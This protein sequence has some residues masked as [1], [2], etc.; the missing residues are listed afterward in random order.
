M[1]LTSLKPLP[2]SAP[3][4]LVTEGAA[5]FVF[6][7]LSRPSGQTAIP[8]YRLENGPESA[9][10]VAAALE[11]LERVGV[12]TLQG[13]DRRSRRIKLTNR[14]RLLDDL[15]RALLVWAASV[16]IETERVGTVHSWRLMADLAF[17]WRSGVLILLAGRT[18]TTVDIAAAA[19]RD[20]GEMAAILDRLSDRGFITK[21]GTDGPTWA[22]LNDAKRAM[23]P[24]AAAV[25]VERELNPHAFGLIKP[26]HV[27]VVS[28]L[29]T[30]LIGSGRSVAALGGTF[31]ALCRLP[32]GR[33]VGS[34]AELDEGS[35][36]SIHPYREGELLDGG[37]RGDIEACL[38]LMAHGDLQAI[39]PFGP[40]RRGGV[41]FTA[42]LTLG[43]GHDPKRAGDW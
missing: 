29:C 37:F 34:V 40:D 15:Y 21:V 43:L 24:L 10:R 28:R 36:Y 11:K 25:L 2:A 38:A 42:A 33:E 20:T 19:E 4:D 7:R 12:I 9:E 6:S 22:L 18:A 27:E 23:V 41:R 13:K 32:D 5:P 31:A 8:A 14:G 39:E 1:P 17:A 35:V 3:L 16:T 30:E 26:A